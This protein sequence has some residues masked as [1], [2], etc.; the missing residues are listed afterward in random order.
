VLWGMSTKA[1]KLGQ[2]RSKPCAFFQE[3]KCIRGDKCRFG[4]FISSGVR[5]QLVCVW[6]HVL[7][8]RFSISAFPELIL[9]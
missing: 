4:H 8:G 5:E 1:E 2:M 9:A 6:S 7:G 3:G